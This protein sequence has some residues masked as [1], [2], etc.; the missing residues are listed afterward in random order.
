[1]RGYLDDMSFV[2]MILDTKCDFCD[3]NW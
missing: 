3:M 2:S 1:L